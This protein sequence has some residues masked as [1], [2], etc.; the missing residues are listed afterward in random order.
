[1]NSGKLSPVEIKKECFDYVEE[2][3]STKHIHSTLESK[4]LEAYEK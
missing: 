3:Y 1:M 2:F 4:S